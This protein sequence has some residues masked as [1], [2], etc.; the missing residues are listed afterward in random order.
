[1]SSNS[2]L[3]YE[4]K[5]GDQLAKL[6]EQMSERCHFICNYLKV[7]YDRPIYYIGFY[8]DKKLKEIEINSDKG[9]NL[10]VN[11]IEEAKE[12]NMKDN[13]GIN[14]QSHSSE[15][16]TRAEERNKANSDINEEDTSETINIEKNNAKIKLK[17]LNE[18]T[19]ENN[20]NIYT[21]KTKD[22]DFSS[23]KYLPARIAIFKLKDKIF[24]EKLIYEKEELNLLGTLNDDVKVIKKDITTI[25]NT[26]NTMNTKIDNIETKMSTMETRMAKTETKMDSFEKLLNAIAGKLGI[27]PN[28][29]LNEKKI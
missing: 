2:L 4:I 9:Q 10:N 8:K 27:D 20:N 12:I 17:E 28:Q 14:G 3:L 21:N 16:N 29:I 15:E 18:I 22:M 7:F 6:K 19:N 11:N 1:M 26:I 25:K 13:N 23:L 24:D 5:S